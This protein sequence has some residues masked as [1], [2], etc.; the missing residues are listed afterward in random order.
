MAFLT[1]VFHGGKTL[2]FTYIVEV[3]PTTMR[4]G[5]SSQTFLGDKTDEVVKLIGNGATLTGLV[6]GLAADLKKTDFITGG[7]VGTDGIPMS[8]VNGLTT[9]AGPKP[10]SASVNGKLL[11]GE[12][13]R[14]AGRAHRGRARGAA[15]ALQPCRARATTSATATPSSIPPRS[16]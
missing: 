4:T 15:V 7:A 9:A 5:C 6:S 1:D 16:S 3:E 12:L 10:T 13:R 2:R 8:Y 14:G 11:T